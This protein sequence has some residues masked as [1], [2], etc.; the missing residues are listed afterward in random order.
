M[1]CTHSSSSSSW[2]ECPALAACSAAT[3]G[4]STTSPSSSSGPSSASSARLPP[5]PGGLSSS[6]GKART[7]VGPDS[8]MY[9]S[10]SSAIARSS[11]SSTDSSASG[12]MRSWSSANL[13]TAARSVSSTSTPDSLAMSML[14][15]ASAPRPPALPSRAR[16]K[17]PV[18]GVVPLVRVDDLSHQP[19]PHH[20]M[21]GQPGEVDVVE[22][23][24]HHAQPADLAGRQVHLGDVAGDHHA[25]AEP[26]PG[27]E[28]LHLL[29][30]G[31]L[32]LVQDDERVV[33]RP[34]AHVRQGGD[35]DGARGHQAGDRVGVEHVVQRVVQ[36]AQVRVDLLVQ[37]P[38][39]EA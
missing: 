5:M 8:S 18:P 17:L 3:C 7:S 22:D 1:P 10:C 27:Q 14:I 2:V 6:M 39:Q 26:E 36:R 20:V 34:S 32:R 35:L 25:G 29:G 19:V 37:G 9:F 33:Q 4:H 15:A 12:W 23:V 21:A 13:A 38:G 16:V 28:H 30:G 11:T 31:V 24:L